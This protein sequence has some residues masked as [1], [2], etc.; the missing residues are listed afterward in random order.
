M[1]LQHD[2]KSSAFLLQQK[3]P[4]KQEVVVVVH[5]PS[6]LAGEDLFRGTC[7]A[8]DQTGHHLYPKDVKLW[9]VMSFTA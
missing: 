7:P 3:S 9:K 5:F 2:L 4:V 6:H 8:K 1:D